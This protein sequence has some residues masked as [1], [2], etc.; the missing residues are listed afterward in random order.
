MQPI[1]SSQKSRNLGISS[2]QSE[3]NSANNY[4]GAPKQAATSKNML[5]QRKLSYNDQHQIGG[6]AE[7]PKP[8]ST[9]GNL[10]K[11]TNKFISKFA[12]NK[13]SG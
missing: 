7:P 11:T 2:H 10:M 6:L 5:G 1:E 12:G 3:K 4:A 9:F 13:S 8:T